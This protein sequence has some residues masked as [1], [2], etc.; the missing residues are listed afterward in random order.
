MKP[1]VRVE[2]RVRVKIRSGREVA[3]SR[4]GGKGG[5]RVDLDQRGLR[6]FLSV[7]EA[8]ELDRD[9]AYPNRD[10]RRDIVQLFGLE[11]EDWVK[12]SRIARKCIAQVFA[13]S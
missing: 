6:T 10:G 12:V 5:V 2:I 8:A 7:G 1:R 4:H 9:I 11:L 13:A 3:S